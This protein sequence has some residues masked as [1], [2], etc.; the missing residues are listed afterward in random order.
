LEEE[1]MKRQVKYSDA[2]LKLL[3]LIPNNGSRITMQQLAKKQYARHPHPPFN[4][5]ASVR[6]TLTNL[7]KK[8]EANDERYR[9]RREGRPL[10]YWQEKR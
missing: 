5:E 10:E 3:E 9:I 1:K 4:P 7:I 8:M 6:S 2:E